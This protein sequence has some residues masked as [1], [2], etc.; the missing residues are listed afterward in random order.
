MCR[1]SVPLTVLVLALS[2]AA[3]K[4]AEPFRYQAGKYGKGEL[5]YINGLPVLIVEGSPD[6]IGAQVGKLT[7]KA[8]TRLLGYSKEFL[9]AK[10]YGQAWPLLVK[11]SKSMLPRFPADH[12]KELEAIAK[13][14]NLN[15]DMAVVGNTLPDIKK[16]GGCATLIIEADHSAT[17]GPLFGRNLDYPTLGFL[18]EYSLVTVYRPRGKHAFVSVGFPGLVGCVSGMNDAGL[19]VATL[20]VYRSKDGSPSLNFRGVP[21]TLCYRRILEECRTVAEAEKLLRSM[22]RTTMNNLAVCDSKGGAVFEI[23]PK[24]VVVRHSESGICPCT[25]HFCCKE[26]AL[27]TRCWRLPI[28]KEC[29]KNGKITLADVAKKMDA[30]N[31]GSL[32]LQTMIF[33]PRTLKLHLAIGKCP[34]TKLPLKELDL[35]TLFKEQ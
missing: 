24:S 20:E 4:G 35:K 11:T 19:A 30:V 2:V 27:P 14:S 21:Y 31:Q 8:L 34:A 9:T 26:L 13:N 23:T 32:T 28:L 7:T 6:E 29:S 10:G 3:V 15:F 5:K 18:Q 25:N 16:F 1:R 17:K 22:K 12:R 33:E